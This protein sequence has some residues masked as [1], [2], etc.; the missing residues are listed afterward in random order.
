MHKKFEMNWPKI[1]GSCQP[2]SK[3]VTHDSKSDLLLEEE[4][5]HAKWHLGEEIPAYT[6]CRLEVVFCVYVTIILRR[7][8]L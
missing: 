6:R 7:P 2:G 5:D 8:D 4:V 1:K 3:V